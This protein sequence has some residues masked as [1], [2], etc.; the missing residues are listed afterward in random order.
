MHQFFVIVVTSPLPHTPLM[1]QA[2]RTLL[3]LVLL[4]A[5]VPSD[6]AAQDS[7]PEVDGETDWGDESS[8]ESSDETR[9]GAQTPEPEASLAPRVEPEE[10]G[11]VLE[12]VGVVGLSAWTIS[13][14]VGAPVSLI[15]V[16]G[17]DVGVGEALLLTTTNLL[18]VGTLGL[19]F[20][21]MGA[22]A[23]MMVIGALGYV[24]TFGFWEEGAA[25]AMTG[26]VIGGVGALLTFVVAPLVFTLN[27]WLVDSSYGSRPNNI[28]LASGAM[29]LGSLAGGAGGFYLADLL[30]DIDEWP[31]LTTFAVIGTSLLVG[32]ISY[33][34][35]R[36]VTDKP[37]PTAVILLPPIVF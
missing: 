32:N 36:R 19:G 17:G 8:D 31:V 12:T 20:A 25:V 22:G 27:N 30:V 15:A 26:L 9:D 6:V 37:G 2:L 35:T 33:A 3:A 5:L 21:V 4:L 13:A 29:I 34:M 7:P 11:G 16:S 24:I 10:E 14:F 18:G 23:A 28:F 1:A